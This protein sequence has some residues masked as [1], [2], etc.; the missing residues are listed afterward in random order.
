MLSAS[1]VGTL[2]ASSA[3]ARA[4]SFCRSCRIQTIQVE[5]YTY[6]QFMFTLHIWIF[7]P[8]CLW[9]I[10]D[11]IADPRKAPGAH[12]IPRIIPL[13]NQYHPPCHPFILYNSTR[14]RFSKLDGVGRVDDNPPPTNYNPLG[15]N[16]WGSSALVKILTIGAVSS[17]HKGCP[18]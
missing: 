13:N 6:N 15:R 12:G 8:L 7:P 10:Q 9:F 5:D 11:N 1:S 17:F 4:S 14:S 3:L 2:S 18:T 16:F